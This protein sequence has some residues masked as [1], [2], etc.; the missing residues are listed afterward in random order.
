VYS[1]I[2]SEI[3]EMG[4]EKETF[5]YLLALHWLKGCTGGCYSLSKTNPKPAAPC[6]GLG[7]YL[8]EGWIFEKAYI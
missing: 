3:T 1:I 5:I 8:K 6:A 7:L 4:E 2:A